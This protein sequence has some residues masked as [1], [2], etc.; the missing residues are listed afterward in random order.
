[1][2]EVFKFKLKIFF[3]KLNFGLGSKNIDMVIGTKTL[4]IWPLIS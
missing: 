2:E 3:V 4:C 1:M